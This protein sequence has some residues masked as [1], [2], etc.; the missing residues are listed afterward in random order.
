MAAA[1]VMARESVGSR[2]VQCWVWFGQAL[3][4][5]DDDHVKKA[6][7]YPCLDHG[8]RIR[9]RTRDDTQLVA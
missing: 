1:G 6:L 2:A 3:L 4:S 9:H 7:P 5:G 8:A